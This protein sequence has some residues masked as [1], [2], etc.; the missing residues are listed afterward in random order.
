MN[1]NYLFAFLSLFLSHMIH[2]QSSD[3]QLP[4]HQIP[5]APEIY[6]ANTVAARMI[7]G[8]GFR[9]YW[10]TEGLREEDL[11][12]MP[13]HQARTTAETLDHI[14]GLCET[15]W[16]AVK[17]QPNIR[18]SS[19]QQ[20]TFEE[21][22]VLTLLR[23]KEAS[24][25][26]RQQDTLTLKDMPIVFQRSERTATFPFWHILNGQLADAIWHVGQVVSFRR[27]SGNPIDGRVDVF[28]GKLRG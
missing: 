7:D 27:S 9:Y 10:A 17:Q 26:L 25:L 2:A 23:L 15:I 13:S 18:P 21:Q 14:Y 3:H 16:N 22:R 8:L 12:F 1:M 4:Y 24:D 28:S 5:E 6:T 20:L 19:S 11:A